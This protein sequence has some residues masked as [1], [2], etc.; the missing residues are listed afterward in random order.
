M[1]DGNQLI[2][3]GVAAGTYPVRR[4]YGEALVR[5]L[6]DGT[7]EV[8]SSSIDMGQGTYTILAQTA[9]E[10]LGV[11]ADNVVV[12]LGNS[13]FARAG[14][15]GGS[16]LAGIMTGAVHKAA[17]CGARPAGRPGDHRSALALPCAAGQHAGRR[18]AAASH[19]RAATDRMFRSPSCSP[20]SGRDQI[21][22][23]GD[24]MPANS[25]AEDRYKN[26]TTIATPLP[27]TDGDYSRH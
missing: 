14:V 16:R 2:G 25:T 26:Y 15:A 6:A 19:R 1:R 20:A 24:T 18:Q 4:A 9:A 22:A 7:V 8:E 13:R 12:K 21:E 27:H 23:T 17:G 11:P 5:I 3:W 10:A